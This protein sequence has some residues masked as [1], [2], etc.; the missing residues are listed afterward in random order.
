MGIVEP[1]CNLYKDHTR[2]GAGLSGVVGT[3]GDLRPA[4]IGGAAR[5]RLRVEKNHIVQDG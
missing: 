4:C 5:A 2:G 3:R 1:D